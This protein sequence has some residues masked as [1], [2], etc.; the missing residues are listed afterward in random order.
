MRTPST[1]IR[2]RLP[3]MP[4]I[5][6]PAWPRRLLSDGTL[7]PGSYKTM[8]SKFCADAWFKVLRPTTDT[9]GA[10]LSKVC[11]LRSAVTTTGSI[12]A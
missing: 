9:F 2:M 3:S 10:A 5:L 11:A 7:T 12:S 1:I 4:R 8:S 6:M